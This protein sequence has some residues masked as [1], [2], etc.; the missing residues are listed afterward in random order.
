[1][2]YHVLRRDAHVHLLDELLV[3]CGQNEFLGLLVD[4]AVCIHPGGLFSPAIRHHVAPVGFMHGLCIV[5]TNVVSGTGA[6]NLIADL[7]HC[8]VYLRCLRRKELVV[9][10]LVSSNRY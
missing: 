10:W 1:M 7:S 5:N 4:R 2:A 6:L 8:I 9:S 3:F